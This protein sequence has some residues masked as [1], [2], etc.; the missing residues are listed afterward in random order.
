V[1]PLLAFDRAVG[2]AVERL[3]RS[4]HHRRLRRLGWEHALEPPDDGLWV[5]G[6]PPPRD[7]NEIEILI[8]GAAA[9]PRIAA[10]LRTARSHA[11]LAGWYISPWFALERDGGNVE[12]RPLLAA[13]ADK[14]DVRVLLWA[15][16]PLPL[17]RP[18]RTDLDG[19]R[20]ALEFGTRIRVGLD[21]KER[22]MHCHHEKLVLV[23]DRIAFVG[24]IDLTT[25]AGDRFDTPRHV[26]RGSIGWHDAAAV[27]RGPIVRDVAEHFRLRWRDVTGEDLPEP[28][29]PRRAGSTTLQFVRTVPE[30]VYEPI[31][32]G[33]FRI[34]EAYTRAF[35]AAQRLIYLENQFFWSSEI[36]EILQDKVAHPPTDGFRLVLVLPANPNNGG[37]DTRGQLADLIECDDGA[38]RVLACTLTALG[39]QGPCPV[40]VHAKIGIVDDAW[41]TLGSANLNEHSLFNDTEV[42]LVCCDETIARETRLRLWAEHLERPRDAVAAD[43]TTVVDELWRPIAREQRRLRDAGEPQTHRLAELRGLSTRTSRLRGPVQGL[44]VDG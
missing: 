20:H 42:N 33:E 8:D 14:V 27:V 10:E 13:L 28:R 38:G 22:P 15:G 26:A 11:H 37:D 44:L 9:L 7:G 19:V 36:A 1:D 35:R 2:N 17:F 29:R 18:D 23:D 31:P 4:H 32:R 39:D 16:S 34:V 3:V 43:P 5:A 21:A 40:Y 30:R 25:M 12:L 6:D 41:L 24:G